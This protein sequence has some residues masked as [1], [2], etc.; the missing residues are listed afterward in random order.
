MS[1]QLV[2]LIL[3]LVLTAAGALLWRS[4]DRS[5]RVLVLV[6]ATNSVGQAGVWLNSLGY[7]W[8]GSSLIA[9]MF[10]I[11]GV[12]IWR[13]DRTV[14]RQ[15]APILWL[16]GAAIATILLTELW[17]SASRET[18][19][20]LLVLLAVLT[21]AFLGW[22]LWSTFRLLWPHLRANRLATR[23]DDSN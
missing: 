21:T 6:N 13:M 8:A 17:T 9:V 5:G 15:M 22:T 16:C 11:M 20:A 23:A 10:G 12:M 14:L 7:L 2:F 19:R 3:W 1:M 4:G 18:V